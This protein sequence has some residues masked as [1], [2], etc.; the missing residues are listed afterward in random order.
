MQL[1][2]VYSRAQLALD[3]PEV[4]VE[5]HP[6]AGLPGLLIVGLVETAVKESKDRV[7]A[8]IANAGLE[9]PNRRIVVSLAPADLPKSGSRFDLAIAIGILAASGQIRHDALAGYEFFGELA[10]SGA[11]RP[12]PGVLP[13]VMQTLRGRRL[14]IVPT[15]CSAEAG[16]L[17]SDRVRTAAHLLDVVRHLQGL[18]Q[19]PGADLAAAE[20]PE[21][22]DADLDEVQGQ[23]QAKR[24]LEIA[25]AGGHNLLMIGPPGTGKSMLAGRLPGL[26]APMGQEQ[27]LVSAALY[28]LAGISRVLPWRKRPFR[29]PHHTASAAALVGGG[30]HPRPGE[31]SLAHGGVLFLDELPEFNRRALEALREP[32]ETGKISIAR[33]GRSAEFPAS[34]Q[35]I[36]AMN[37]CPC[38]FAGD[39]E[40]DCRCSPE[41]IRRYRGKI[42]GPFI[43]RIDI[44]VELTRVGIDWTVTP[45]TDG[46]SSATVRRRV[47]AAVHT[48]QLRS[49]SMNARFSAAEL[50][51]YCLPDCVGQDLLRHARQ[52]FALSA[53]ACDSILRVART[54]ADLAQQPTISAAQ[55]SEA[56]ALRAGRRD[57]DGLQRPCVAGPGLNR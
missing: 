43:D 27:S 52:K 53:R 6:S 22:P 42:S 16:L 5:V 40:R 23:H 4:T 12:I 45:R 54:I 39:P 37:P 28:S 25:A 26:L 3:A 55:L 51:T 48:Q 57:W 41:Q 14:A 11:V 2:T 24:A 36:A 20:P 17:R 31:I 30:T 33:A 8:A 38:G 49:G 35:L 46:E 9:M 44:A 18:D 7:R 56:L 10:L 29:A 13:A 21:T 47:A 1:A 19:L 50:H 32:L 34:F 15:G